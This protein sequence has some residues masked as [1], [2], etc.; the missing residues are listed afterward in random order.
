M[1]IKHFI[2]VSLFLPAILLSDLIR[3]SP[4]PSKVENQRTISNFDNYRD[5]EALI[6]FI[7]SIIQTNLIP[8]VS[9]SIVKDQ[10]IVWEKY[11]GYADI[12]NEILVDE[13]TMFILSSVSKTITATALMQLWEQGLFELDDNINSYLPFEVIHPDYPFLGIS[14]FKAGLQG[15]IL[16]FAAFLSSLVSPSTIKQGQYLF[17]FLNLLT[18]KPINILSF[19]D[20]IGFGENPIFSLTFSANSLVLSNSVLNSS[21]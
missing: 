2:L 1:N 11:F 5:E 7:E 12:D 16:L 3:N 17:P 15:Q 20:S 14:F 8:G 6:E 18:V 21:D 19:S 9:V 13:E 10:H 4:P